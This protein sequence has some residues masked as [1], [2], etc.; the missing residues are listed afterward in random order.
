M[1]VRIFTHP[2][3]DILIVLVADRDQSA[4]LRQ[5]G[6]RHRL[7][8]FFVFFQIQHAVNE[9]DRPILPVIIHVGMLVFVQRIFDGFGVDFV[10]VIKLGSVC[11]PVAVQ[12][13][14]GRVMA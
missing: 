1:C 3:D 13:D 12:V 11:N 5:K 10:L 6:E 9:G 8:I 7:V 4:L 2:A 14:P